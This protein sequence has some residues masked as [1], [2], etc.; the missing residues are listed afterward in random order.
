MGNHEV[1]PS[2]PRFLLAREAEALG[3]DVIIVEADPRAGRTVIP[4]SEGA[5]MTRAEI[6]YDTQE[7]IF[8]LDTAGE[9]PTAIPEDLVGYLAIRTDRDRGEARAVLR[10][11]RGD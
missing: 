6:R 11:A 3:I 7:R 8:W 9:E 4:Y 1:L 2:V 5:A 10:G